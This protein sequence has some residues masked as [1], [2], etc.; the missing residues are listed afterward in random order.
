MRSNG[1]EGPLFLLRLLDQVMTKG[2]DRQFQATCDAKLVEDRPEVVA[3]CYFADEQPLGNLLVLEP[4]CN[5]SNDLALALG[6][7]GDFGCLRI[8]LLG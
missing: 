4:L 2:I 8:E 7:C 3:H 6:Q 1:G 5:Q